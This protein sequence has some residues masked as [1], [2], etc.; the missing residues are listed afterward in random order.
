MIY[1]QM[2]GDD[3]TKTLFLSLT[4]VSLFQVKV[5]L[6]RFSKCCVSRRTHHLTHCC[7]IFLAFI[8]TNTPNA[9][10]ELDLNPTTQHLSLNQLL[11]DACCILA[12]MLLLRHP[13]KAFPAQRSNNQLTYIDYQLYCAAISRIFKCCHK[14]SNV[15]QEP[16]SSLDC[17]DKYPVLP[18]QF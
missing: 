2:I 1:K 9:I 6:S 16:P 18:Y 12:G 17:G 4:V 11:R 3:K 10:S 8:Y 7:S 13:Q 14:H 15:G 5:L